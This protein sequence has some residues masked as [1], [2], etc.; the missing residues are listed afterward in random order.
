MLTPASA[1]WTATRVRDIRVWNARPSS[2]TC[3]PPRRLTA[4]ICLDAISVGVDYEGGVVVRAI[5]TPHR[6]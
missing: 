1:R 3:M 2:D 4:E 5:V 6:P